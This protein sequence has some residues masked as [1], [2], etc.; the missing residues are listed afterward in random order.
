MGKG[1]EFCPGQRVAA[2]RPGLVTRPGAVRVGSGPDL[3][4]RREGPALSPS[5]LILRTIRDRHVLRGRLRMSGL[6]IPLVIIIITHRS[7]PSSS[8]ATVD[9]RSLPEQHHHRRQE[10]EDKDHTGSSHVSRRDVELTTAIPDPPEKRT[11]TV[12]SSP[13]RPSADD[14]SA[15]VTGPEDS[16]R[17]SD[18]AEDE[19][20]ARV[21]KSAVV[22]DSAGDA[23]SAEEK[24]SAVADP[25]EHEDSAGTAGQGAPARMTAARSQTPDQQG[26]DS[27]V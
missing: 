12:I 19:D 9:H 17:P 6:L 23:N 3:H 16:A 18:S 13:A 26:Q 10:N 2:L 25:T 24:D 22:D 7:L 20:W 15:G 8:R 27:V 11:I 14:D 5:M 21:D 4:P 1:R